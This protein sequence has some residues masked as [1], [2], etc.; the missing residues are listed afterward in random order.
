MQNQV[1]NAPSF[2][3]Q[4]PNNPGSYPKYGTPAPF[5]VQDRTL[6]IQNVKHYASNPNLSLDI[7]NL[8]TS[9]F[10]SESSGQTP[11]MPK[12]T[13]D[14]RSPPSHSN[15]PHSQPPPLRGARSQ[16]TQSLIIGDQNN[17]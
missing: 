3:T 7:N 9:Q 5:K 16:M 1:H 12:K 10:T 4:Q 8:K 15:Y 11:N 2:P 13:T 17:I 14:F 6:P